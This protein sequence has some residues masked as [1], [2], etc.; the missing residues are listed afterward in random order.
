MYAVSKERNN[1][2]RVNQMY[3]GL[4]LNWKLLLDSLGMGILI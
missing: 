3:T 1:Q 2:K 4:G